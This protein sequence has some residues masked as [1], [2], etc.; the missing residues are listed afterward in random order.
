VELTQRETPAEVPLIGFGNPGRIAHLEEQ[1]S[2]L[3]SEIAELKR[4]FSAFQK[5]FES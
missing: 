3:Q 2:Q 4:E 5:Q 1:V